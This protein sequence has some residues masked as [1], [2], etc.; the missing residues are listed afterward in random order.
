MNN[1]YP[2]NWEKSTLFEVCQ[3][4]RTGD[5][6]NSTE[7]AEK[8]V[9]QGCRKNDRESKGQKY[10]ACAIAI[11]PALLS[12]SGDFVYTWLRPKRGLVFVAGLRNLRNFA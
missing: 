3:I 9:G 1:I 5:S 12:K 2:P 4:I 6:I 10:F 11:C 8:Y 7:K